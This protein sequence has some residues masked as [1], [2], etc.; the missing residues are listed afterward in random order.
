MEASEPR[1][2]PIVLADA[3]SAFASRIHFG[4]PVEEPKTGPETTV[5]GR[6]LDREVSGRYIRFGLK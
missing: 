4:I 1:P 3:P 6:G 2:I 5:Q